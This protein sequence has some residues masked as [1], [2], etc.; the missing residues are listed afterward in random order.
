[1]DHEILLQ[2]LTYYGIV[3]SSHLW[4]VSY[5]TGRLQRVCYHSTLS[6]F[7]AVKVG[8]PQGSILGHLLFSIYIN[9]LPHVV[10]SCDIDLILVHLFLL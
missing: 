4:F 1:M 9:D 5:L 3:N 6:K 7:G 8:V 10:S 2:K